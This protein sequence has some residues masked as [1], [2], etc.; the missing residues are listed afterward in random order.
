MRFSRLELIRYG[1]FA[2]RH[3]DFG[4]GKPDL[5]LVVGPNE[6]G[7]STLLAAISDL[8][9]GIAGQ[10]P[11]AWR[12]DYSQ[13]RLRAVL[14]RDGTR[15]DVIRRKGNKETLLR[16][17][18]TPFAQDPLLPLLAG[19]DRSVFERMFG[20]DHAQLRAGGE[21]ILL[22]KDDAARIVLEAGTG[23]S[24]IGSQLAALEDLASSLFKPAGQN[25]VINKL[26]RERSDAASEVKQ[27]ALSDSELA[28]LKA[29]R[30][31]AVDRREALIEEAKELDTEQAK[32]QRIGR[33][34]RPLSTLE[35]A[36]L[37]LAQLGDVPALPEDASRAL[38]T[39]RAERS[40][41]TELKAKAEA[42]RDKAQDAIDAIHL[43]KGLLAARA[44]IEDL[45]ERRPVYEKAMED[46]QRR[47]AELKSCDER[48]AAARADAMLPDDAPLPSTGWRRRV[49]DHLGAERDAKQDR[50]RY[51]RDLAS[52]T[53]DQN[54]VQAQLDSL[55]AVM[56]LE[57]LE[58]AV[59]SYPSDGAK[60]LQLQQA[61]AAEKAEKAKAQLAKLQPWLG[62]AEALAAMILPAQGELNRVRKVLAD[63]QAGIAAEEKEI[64]AQQQAL[65]DAERRLQTLEAGETLPTAD[66]IAAARSERDAALQ[67]VRHRLGRDRSG[68]DPAAGDALAATITQSDVLVDRRAAEAARVADHATMTAAITAATAL[69]AQA[70]ERL[71]QHRQALE[72]EQESW[73][74][75]LKKLGFAEPILPE[76][77]ATWLANREMA[78]AAFDTARVAKR[79]LERLQQ[80]VTTATADLS[81]ALR[82]SG[83]E[84]P[85]EGTALIAEA[86]RR[87]TSFQATESQR[88][89]LT[90]KLSTYAERTKALTRQKSDLE[91]AEAERKATVSSL[92]QEGAL[93]ET[94]G[95]R[96]L[97]DASAALEAVSADIIKRVQLAYQVDSMTTLTGSFCTDVA[98]LLAN[99]GREASDHPAVA[100]RQL[101]DDLAKAIAAEQSLAKLE[102]DLNGHEDD[103]AEANRRLTAVASIITNLMTL[104]GVQHE[105]ALD[106]MLSAHAQQAELKASEAAAKAELAELA[107]G[108]DLGQLRAEVAAGGEDDATAR[109][110]AIAERRTEINSER[111]TIGR[112][113]NEIDRQMDDAAITSAAAEAQQAVADAGAALAAESEKF[114]HAAS[115]AALLRWLINKHRATRQAPLIA[116]A[117]NLFAQVTR[118]A[119]AGLR[120][121]YDSNDRPTIVGVRADGAEVDAQGMSEGT[122]DQLFLSLRLGSIE[123]RAGTGSLPLICDDLL[124]TADDERAGAMLQALSTVAQTSQVIVFSHHDHVVDLAN[125]AVGKDR[126]CLHRIAPVLPAEAA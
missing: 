77:F 37:S 93:S 118:G 56:G 126:F 12:Y 69:K 3:L 8:F 64:R 35:A 92:L 17:D 71:D 40:T 82:G 1:G 97:E 73:A 100:A 79:S 70:E 86:Q 80:E 78:L 4:A 44:R 45:S 14:E 110:K 47:K 90:T 95:L 57:A 16:P 94:A 29:A 85:A 106:D 66:A 58:L 59:R 120:I 24:N 5:H 11:H 96:G 76:D 9:F 119:F 34:R 33:A 60:Q 89:E 21:A 49:M 31:K 50:I 88:K 62:D 20:L 53:A 41:A 39:A 38:Q 83:A 15:L 72:R 52:L 125:R 109:L 75:A 63:A 2:D 104:A 48:I 43:P 116:R 32:L 18:G 108:A 107:P 19:I 101:A 26:M 111:E 102:A 123:E 122:R 124:I 6:A 117:G 30:S 103:L 68:D 7:K 113:L 13:L 10:T 27:N 115:A 51:E 36:Q 42:A 55:P 91:K 121:A 81:A 61:D 65:V 99:L 54:E 23:L 105:A 98:A 28:D 84:V 114:I 46:L 112:E 25:P 74:K 22:G 67:D 87:L